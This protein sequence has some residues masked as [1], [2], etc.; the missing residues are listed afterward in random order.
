[1]T[2]Q[3]LVPDSAPLGAVPS[4]PYSSD[5]LLCVSLPPSPLIS[6]S[7]SLFLSLSLP[8][9]AENARGVARRGP[10]K[11]AHHV[12]P[13]CAPAVSLFAGLKA[14]RGGGE[15]TRTSRRTKSTNFGHRLLAWRVC[16]A[17]A[18]SMTAEIRRSRPTRINFA[19]A[20]RS[21]FYD[22]N[23]QGGFAERGGAPARNPIQLSGALFS[24]SWLFFAEARSES[25][26]AGANLRPY[27]YVSGLTL[28]P[29]RAL[30]ARTS[31]LS[32]P[33]RPVDRFE[34]SPRAA[35]DV[36]RS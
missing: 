20:I 29:P 17:A 15:V 6:L 36:T 10:D 5:S 24:G 34:R 12:H 2:G 16:A 35:L 9:S 1:V 19:R 26:L 25:A 7:L 31:A 13:S 30:S 22:V 28:P 14:S 18:R 4:R 11:G 32:I 8:F 23:L 27:F 33:P 21:D 3:K